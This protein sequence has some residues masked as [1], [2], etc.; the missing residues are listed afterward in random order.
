MKDAQK[1]LLWFAR[2]AQQG[3]KPDD[4]IAETALDGDEPGLSGRHTSTT[5][6]RISVQRYS[7]A[8][9]QQAKYTNQNDASGTG[10]KKN[11]EDINEYQ[12]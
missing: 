11:S 6:T 7:H 5:P 9:R 2:N 3:K 12:L 4:G 10:T 1:R 8:L